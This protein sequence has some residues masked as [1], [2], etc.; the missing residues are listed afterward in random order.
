MDVLSANVRALDPDI[1]GITES[2][3]DETISDAEVSMEG[4]DLFRCDRPI[5]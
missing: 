2:W 1:I 4:Y 3:M 5:K